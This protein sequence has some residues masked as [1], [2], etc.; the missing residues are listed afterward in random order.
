MSFNSQLLWN[1]Q[2]GFMLLLLTEKLKQKGNCA[3]ADNHPKL[4]RNVVRHLRREGQLERGRAV[5]VRQWGLI[6]LPESGL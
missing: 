1:R 5:K 2:A 6:H 3:P 4:Q